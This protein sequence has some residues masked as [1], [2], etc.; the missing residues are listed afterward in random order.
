MNSD[1]RTD[2]GRGYHLLWHLA[3]AGTLV[4]GPF[5]DG[6]QR[7]VLLDEWVSR[8]RRLEGD[9]ALGELVRRHLAGRG[10]ATVADIAWWTKLGLR[11]VR[12]GLEAV[13]DE[14]VPF[15]RAGTPHWGHGPSLE[16]DAAARPRTTVL[17]PGFDEFLLG[18][19]DRDAALDPAHAPLTVP[20][21]N[22][23]FRPT[24]MHRGRIVGVWS[25]RATAGR[26]T[27]TATPFDRALPRAAVA[28][29]ERMAREYGRFL[30]TA[31]ALTTAA[32]TG[33]AG[34]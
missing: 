7:F 21:G 16:R 32:P 13:R 18:Y 24:I 28:E 8:P 34:G 4:L 1:G 22:G 19:R 6:E 9:E 26:T 29:M 33:P 17:L 27:I 25:R 2:A 15:D 31:A 5:Q 23:V 3:L 10:P 12:T 20:G 14:L 11:E 30:G